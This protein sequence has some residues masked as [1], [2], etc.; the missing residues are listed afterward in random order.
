[1]PLELTY[2]HQLTYDAIEHSAVISHLRGVLNTYVNKPEFSLFY[3]GITSDLNTR[4]TTHQ[5]EK[6]EFK[7]MCAIYEESNPTANTAFHA[8]ERDTINA[9]R[10]GIVNPSDAAKSMRCTNDARG[11]SPKNWLYILVG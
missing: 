7:R 8:L 2:E 6:P 9:L 10:G 3:I 4:R 5:R 11:S 1:M